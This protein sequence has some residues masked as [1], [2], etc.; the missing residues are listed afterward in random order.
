LMG[1]VPTSSTIATHNTALNYV[2]RCLT[3]A[4][5]EQLSGIA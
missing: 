5:M 3:S 1:K 2:F 4:P